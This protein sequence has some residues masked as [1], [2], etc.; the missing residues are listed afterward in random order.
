M[1]T[2]EDIEGLLAGIIYEGNLKERS[3]LDAPDFDYLQK[4][5][6]QVH[7]GA[8]GIVIVRQAD[9]NLRYMFSNSDRREAM[10]VLSKVMERT[11][12]HFA[13]EDK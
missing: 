1:E 7:R 10:Q 12:N 3:L 6:Y 4:L 11:A 13:N 8:M 2:P 9:G 5:V